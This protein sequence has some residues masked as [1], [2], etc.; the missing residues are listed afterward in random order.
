MNK[1]LVGFQVMGELI[2]IGKSVP[3]RLTKKDALNL[4][5]WLVVMAD[6]NPGTKDSQFD[7]MLTEVL[8][9]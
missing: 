4:A 7:K 5:A 1:F 3:A 8:N 9:T 2:V 6:E